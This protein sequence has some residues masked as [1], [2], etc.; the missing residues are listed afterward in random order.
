LDSSD[1]ISPF[2]VPTMSE[3]ATTRLSEVLGGGGV[4]VVAGAVAIDVAAGG[5]VSAG[6]AFAVGEPVV[7]EGVHSVTGLSGAGDPWLSVSC[8]SAEHPASSAQATTR[9]GQRV[10]T[11]LY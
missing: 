5:V 11:T 4:V 9:R 6:L 10:F 2:H 7:T 8:F 1:L 3:L